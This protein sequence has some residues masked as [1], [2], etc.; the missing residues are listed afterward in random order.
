MALA[1]ELFGAGNTTAVRPPGM[2][3]AWLFGVE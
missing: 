3:A 2:L 1:T